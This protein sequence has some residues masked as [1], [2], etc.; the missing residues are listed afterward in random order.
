ML[1][2]LTPWKRAPVRWKVFLHDTIYLSMLWYIS[3][4]SRTAMSYFLFLSNFSVVEDGI[5]G[6]RRTLFCMPVQ[7]S[8]KDL[9]T[10][11]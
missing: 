2:S 6:P 8:Q 3:V 4:R 1:N 11:S 7:N 9:P 10:L 5:V